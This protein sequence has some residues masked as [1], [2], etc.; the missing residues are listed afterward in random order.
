MDIRAPRKPREQA[1]AETPEK[2]ALLLSYSDP[3]LKG[4]ER[5][6]I[7]K[8][9][10]PVVRQARVVATTPAVAAPVRVALV[11]WSKIQYRGVVY[12]P[13]RKR[14]M[15]ALTIN[16]TEHF[17]Q[18]GEKGDGLNVLTITT[19]SIEVSVDGARKYLRKE[20]D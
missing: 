19:D 8:A 14:K 11:N 15:A 10:Q 16:G 2:Y 9:V 18:E 3:F 20:G 7:V 4:R 13:S 5:R 17:L 12:N 1:A 6:D